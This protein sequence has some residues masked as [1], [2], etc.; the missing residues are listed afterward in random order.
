MRPAVWMVLA[1]GQTGIL[2]APATAAAAGS[3]GAAVLPDWA[4]PVSPPGPVVPGNAVA[5][6]DDGAS[7]GAIHVPGSSVAFRP[8]QLA[9]LYRTP[10]WFPADHAPMPDVVAQGRKP[11]LYACA[12][13]H[14]PDGAGRPENASLAGLPAAY[15]VQQMRDMRSGARSSALPD[16]LPFR[17]MQAVSLAATEDELETAA[18]Y[19]SQLRPPYRVQVVETAMVPRTHVAGWILVPDA[20]TLREP[21]GE[22]IVETPTDLERFE[23]RDPRVGFIAYVPPGSIR[24]GA[25]L[26]RR[27]GPGRTVACTTCH[28][29]DLGGVAYVPRLAGRSPSYLVRQLYD[30]QSGARHGAAGAAMKAVVARLRPGEEIAIAA[31]L[32][33]LH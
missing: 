22:R 10:D 7:A 5:L 27:G 25:A 4:Y 15:I 33:T 13:C 2:V 9:D 6:A 17:F 24:A 11:G 26:V 29:G 31:Y 8:A 20:G 14:L 18:R 21:I 1:I 19:F 16:R 23:H 28:G 12:Y 3:A 32:A 30:F